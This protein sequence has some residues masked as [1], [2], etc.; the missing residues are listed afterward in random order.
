M[1]LLKKLIRLFY[2][3]VMIKEWN[4]LLAAIE[5]YAYGTS[6]VLLIEKEEI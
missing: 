6:K 3:Q 1:F 5:T 2:V 4:Q